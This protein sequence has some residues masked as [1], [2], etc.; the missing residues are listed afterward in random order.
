MVK[1][2]QMTH[3]IFRNPLTTRLSH[4]QT[5]TKLTIRCTEIDQ[6]CQGGLTFS[7]KLFFVTQLH[8]NECDAENVFEERLSERDVLTLQLSTCLKFVP[9][10]VETYKVV[11]MLN[12][13]VSIA[14]FVQTC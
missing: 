8:A 4:V 13:K 5:V 12:E 1:M 14:I 6:L 10:T 9:S 11:Y 7:V 3:P 2:L